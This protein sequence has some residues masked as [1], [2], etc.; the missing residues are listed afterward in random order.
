MSADR[1]R[2]PLQVLGALALAAAAVGGFTP[3]P[4]VLYARAAAAEDVQPA[5]AIV[6]LSSN[7]DRE[8]RLS[9]NSLRRAVHGIALQRR[10]LAPLLVLLGV[11]HRAVSEA[12]ERAR[13]AEEFGVPKDA[14][15]PTRA[16]TTTRDEVE[17]VRDVLRPS[18]ARRIL[19]VTGALHMPRASALFRRAG[20]VVHAAPVA[21]VSP[22]A[23]YPSAR[24]GL[25]G[26]V[27]QE[28]LARAYYR[29]A[30]FL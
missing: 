23:T 15:R 10:G 27:L 29:L 18:G 25:L 3:L 14:L 12:E 20:F 7:V 17:R 28:L 11:Q 9:D 16:V 5:D 21:D 6:V 13:L 19:L 8:G 2:L 24:L 4:N 26:T 1:L 22:H 30:G